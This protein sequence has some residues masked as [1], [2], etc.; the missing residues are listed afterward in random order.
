M[1]R[2]RSRGLAIVSAAALTAGVFGVPP[3]TASAATTGTPFAQAQFA[4]YGTGSELHVGALS[5]GGI[6]LAQIE[7]G[8]SSNTVN[9]GGL[10]GVLT[11]PITK[12]VVQSNQTGFITYGRGSGA[13]VG[14]GV[15]PAQENQLQ[16]AL[17]EAHAPPSSGLVSKTAIPVDLSPLAQALL[18]SGKAAAAFSPSFCPIGKPLA[19]GEGD[20][21]AGTAVAGSPAPTALVSGTGASGT[22]AAQSRTRTDLVANADGTFGIQ[23]TVQEIIAPVTINLVPG[24]LAGVSIALTVQGEGPNSP[25]TVATSNDGEGRTGVTYLNSNPL[26]ALD[27]INTVAGVPTTTR[28]L[29]VPVSLLHA[30]IAPLLGTGG[31]LNTLL[32]PAGVNLTV[33]VGGATD[34]FVAGPASVAYDLIRVNA[35]VG[36][37]A[38]PTLQIADVRVGH[39]E[40]SVQLPAGPIACTIPVGKTANPMSVTAGNNFTQTI[41]I[42]SSASAMSDSTCDLTQISATDTISVKSGSPT[43]TVGAISNGGTYNPGTHVITWANLGNYHIGDPPIQ[44]TVTFSVP[45]TSGVGVLQ[46]LAFVNAHL[47]NCTGNATGQASLVGNIGNLTLT[48]TQMLIG[49]NV[50]AGN[51]GNSALAATGSGPIL[52]WAGALLLVMAEGTRRIVRRARPQQLS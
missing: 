36:P 3:T 27:L 35:S 24:T 13:E 38:N 45:S 28:L 1:I 6:T 11:S 48:G 47:Y 16:L 21:S 20:A 32:G 12:A 29:D 10:G 7:Q 5:T 4:A 33:D 18:I 17:A 31:L 14:L 25:F 46:D 39:V 34:G 42:P 30:A 8:F 50:G 43:Y 52:A 15:S 37:V 2:H 41:S 26:V 40:S 19:F 49:P 23:N 51:G 22:Q 9:S 44:L